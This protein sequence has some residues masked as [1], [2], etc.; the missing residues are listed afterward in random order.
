MYF[1]TTVTIIVKNIYKMFQIST[2]RNSL[3]MYK[4]VAKVRVV[5]YK[6]VKYIAENKEK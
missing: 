4:V 5:A 6:G 2:L 3:I 1:V